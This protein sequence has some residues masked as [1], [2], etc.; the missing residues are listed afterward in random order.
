[1]WILS[2][3]V[4]SNR[5]FRVMAFE[6]LGEELMPEL[7]RLSFIFLLSFKFGW[8]K[9]INLLFK[10]FNFSHK[11]MCQPYCSIQSLFCL[12]VPISFN[13]TIFTSFLEL[14]V[15]GLLIWWNLFFWWN[16]RGT[17]LG[18]CQYEI[19]LIIFSFIMSGS[20]RILMQI[21]V[22]IVAKEFVFHI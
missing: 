2:P 12:S 9:R 6:V 17:L 13:N 7:K 4:K 22:I 19:L 1:M 16:L 15:V 5:F 20:I 3:S 21:C 14:W 10:L 18:R 8:F 11:S